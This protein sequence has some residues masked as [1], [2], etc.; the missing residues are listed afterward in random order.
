MMDLNLRRNYTASGSLDNLH[1]GHHDEQSYPHYHSVLSRHLSRSMHH[2]TSVL[3]KEKSRK[4]K[5]HIKESINILPTI[6]DEEAKEEPL[7]ITEEAEETAE[8]GKHSVWKNE[9]FTLSK[10]IRENSIAYSAVLFRIKC[11][12]FTEFFHKVF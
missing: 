4:G 7:K 5:H 11:V 1:H 2:S 6:E 8:S 3:D 12:D 9:N 10:I